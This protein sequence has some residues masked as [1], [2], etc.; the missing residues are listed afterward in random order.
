VLP[1]G[2]AAR[3]AR[4]DELR[5]LSYVAGTALAFTVGALRSARR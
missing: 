5:A 2:L 3:H 4:R 1:L